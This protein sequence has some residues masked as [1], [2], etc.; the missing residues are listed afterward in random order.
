MLFRNPFARSRPRSYGLVTDPEL[1]RV[2]V[3]N[4]ATW[5]N[6]SIAIKGIRDHASA[7]LVRGFT[8][9]SGVSADHYRRV[10][11]PALNKGAV[12]ELSPAMAQLTLDH[13]RRWP[14]DRELPLCRLTHELALELAI[15]LLFGDD[16]DRA[17]PIAR[18][19]TKGLNSS[20]FIPTPGY[21]AWLKMAPLQERAI[22][23]WAADKRG[24]SKARD[25]LTLL[26]NTPDENGGPPNPERIAA[27][28]TFTFAAAFDTCQNG[29]AWTL[30]LL[31]QHPK[32]VRALADEI[33][34]AVGDAPPNINLI[35]ALPLLDSG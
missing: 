7:R 31:T 34:A 8:R 20:W 11:A 2:L 16:H 30:I 6:V 29:V 4:G 17:L 24:D 23:D 32:I 12:A 18:M 35:G 15:S 9:L 19:I 26:A 33:D 14:H 5:R 1:Y 28:L 10:I 27:L 21:L 3:S 25:L 13:V 22:I